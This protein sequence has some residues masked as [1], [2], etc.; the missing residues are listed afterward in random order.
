MKKITTILTVLLLFFMTESKAQNSINVAITGNCSVVQGVYTFLDVFNGKNRYSLT[1]TVSGSTGTGYIQYNGTQ[2]VLAT[3]TTPSNAF[4][5]T[6]SGIGNEPPY[7]GWQFA[8]CGNG[9]LV[10]NTV[11]SNEQF[12]QEKV[13]IYPNPVTDFF[14]IQSSKQLNEE[15]EYKICDL[16]GRTIKNGKSK[17]NEKINVEQLTSGNYVL[18]IN[19]NNGKKVNQKLIKK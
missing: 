4:T 7:T 19:D 2:W 16:T 17:L 15:S 3:T 11:L 1:F 5:N 8:A 6:T 13:M 12:E 18:L 10:I 9:T 14:I